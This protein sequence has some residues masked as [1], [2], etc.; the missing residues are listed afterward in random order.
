MKSAGR[1]NGAL[2]VG[3]G[4]VG[5]SAV[6]PF[7]YD[8]VSGLPANALAPPM[9]TEVPAGFLSGRFVQGE[10]SGG[11]AVF[12]P[13]G[14][15]EQPAAK[16]DREHPFAAKAAW[17]AAQFLWSMNA[18]VDDVAR[19]VFP[20]VFGGAAS[21]RQAGSQHAASMA[22]SRTGGG[23]GR[24]G[25]SLAANGNDI[26]GGGK[27]DGSGS[28]TKP[29]TTVDLASDGPHVVD[30]SDRNLRGVGI[31]IGTAKNADVMLLGSGVEGNIVR[32]KRSNGQME[33]EALVEGVEI[34]EAGQD[35]VFMALAVDTS[36]K[37]APG[38][39]KQIRIGGKSMTVLLPSDAVDQAA[40]ASSTESS[41]RGAG[42]ST[43]KDPGPATAV[44]DWERVKP[45][46]VEAKPAAAARPRILPRG[47][48]KRRPT[49]ASEAPTRAREIS[50][51]PPEAAAVHHDGA[52]S[53]RTDEPEAFID[54]MDGASAAAPTPLAAGRDGS[55]PIGMVLDEDVPGVEIVRVDGAL[56]IRDNRDPVWLQWD[57]VD[58]D[59][60][61]NFN[62]GIALNR[63]LVGGMPLEARGVV[64]L[65]PGD[66]MRVGFVSPGTV[67][68]LNP[69]ERAAS[70]FFNEPSLQG[71]IKAAS[72]VDGI[73]AALRRYGDAHPRSK[74]YADEIIARINFV[75]RNPGQRAERAIPEA[76]RGDVLR[77]LGRA[78]AVPVP[79]AEAAQAEPRTEATARSAEVVAVNL[80]QPSAGPAITFESGGDQGRRF[81]L[82]GFDP[83]RDGTWRLGRS[84]Q[85]AIALQDRRVS[86]LHAE[87]L[88]GRDGAGEGHFFIRDLGSSNGTMVNGVRIGAEIRL[89]DGDR[90][91]LAAAA[92]I[93][94]SGG[95]ASRSATS[96]G[97]AAPA[98][99]QPQAVNP[100]PESEMIFD[101]SQL[102]ESP[103]RTFSVEEEK[104]ALREEAERPVTDPNP[105]LHDLVIAG[106]SPSPEAFRATP[107]GLGNEIVRLFGTSLR[108]VMLRR[109][110]IGPMLTDGRNFR[111]YD[112]A[113]RLHHVLDADLI[114][115]PLLVNGQRVGAEGIILLP[116]DTLYT[117]LGGPGRAELPKA[118][119]QNLNFLRGGFFRRVVG[120]DLGL[121]GTRT[122]SELR[123]FLRGM[124][125]EH[126]AVE[127]IMHRLDR[128]MNGEASI[129]FLP[130]EVARRVRSI[131]RDGGEPGTT[132]DDAQDSVVSEQTRGR[133]AVGRDVPA[134][135]IPRTI[136]IDVANHRGHR[137][138]PDVP[139][140]WD[141]GG[142]MRTSG[143]TYIELPPVG[144]IE[145][146]DACLRLVY[147]PTRG[148]FL[149]K[150]PAFS[151]SART[152]SAEVPAFPSR[153]PLSPGRHT[154]S[155]EH[156]GRRVLLEVQI[157]EASVQPAQ[158][159]PS[160]GARP[161][162]QG[163][164]P[165]GARPAGREAAGARAAG[166]GGAGGQRSPI[167]AAPA[168]VENA[169]RFQCGYS[170]D[171]ARGIADLIKAALQA[172]D[173]KM[174]LANPDRVHGIAL[175]LMNAAEK[176]EGI[177]DP[178]FKEMEAVLK[179]VQVAIRPGQNGQKADGKVEEGGRFKAIARDLS[180]PISI[181]GFN[182]PQNPY[183]GDSP[184]ERTLSVLWAALRQ[185]GR[186]LQ[187][188][189][190]L[191][192]LRNPLV[193]LKAK[194]GVRLPAD[195]EAEL[196]SGVPARMLAAL[197]G[198]PN[199]R[200]PG[201]R[202]INKAR[203]AL[204]IPIPVK[205]AEAP[206]AAEAAPAVNA[207]SE[208]VPTIN[209]IANAL[210]GPARQ[211]GIDIVTDQKRSPL[212]TALMKLSYD[213][214][215]DDPAKIT[216]ATKGR[217][218][219][220]LEQPDPKGV[221]EA[222]KEMLKGYEGTD[223]VEGK[224]YAALVE[225]EEEFMR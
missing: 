162:A 222:L 98:T 60:T 75:A 5:G 197:E 216:A 54:W 37:C 40:G 168:F 143:S 178:A 50:P 86:V 149:V 16:E 83:Q 140:T 102:I 127:E 163:V 3:P 128:V 74:P 129:G 210:R 122:I 104:R 84:R 38:I 25:V 76:I 100:A 223:S 150:Y 203:A 125:A 166:N 107:G 116:G 46:P 22:A 30:L 72:T 175:R 115:L 180:E 185:N 63:F 214:K 109:T 192:A 39:R 13:L 202:A 4:V 28:G 130:E 2:G 194:E 99:R 174:N 161:V 219:R 190:E 44:V 92:F 171:T 51:N 12:L 224:G 33:I 189:P 42:P 32:I 59:K 151:G 118:A 112:E 191:A 58:V 193:A 155:I 97:G 89:N 169:L 73:V 34:G 123:S 182:G 117:P 131:I 108:G 110:R 160:Q 133:G 29:K 142:G 61:Q 132:I 208:P 183:T 41:Q 217:L 114:D 154:V 139:S 78:P 187:N 85:N 62:M 19:T 199:F 101:S 206:K 66:E 53:G 55:K 17:E 20:G 1:G 144:F 173:A 48:L 165:Q 121:R 36:E 111:R 6:M 212:I 201:V 65:L 91:E 145:F 218:D 49:D 21:R 80:A 88:Y 196:G 71:E 177:D 137:F 68:I 113:V 94:Q 134:A 15:G 11:D 119:D 220:A 221:V 24:K 184:I 148:F 69:L 106:G 10:A 135:A 56:A 141:I 198:L 159:A 67:R 225:Y 207:P 64:V 90:V 172:E 23:L 103:T 188:E 153:I 200:G 57:Q 205:K 9:G 126:P 179:E 82:A 136:T 195:I 81:E 35:T 176:V 7:V 211:K 45:T 79:R 105:A 43:A 96:A 52:A 77:V 138:S 70:T 124:V 8:A 167:D 93:F 215:F 158:R 14:S 157:P 27:A 152:A 156:R 181:A 146:P 164:P 213:G 209:R 47:G 186:D 95:L 18:F 87:I 147:E 204:G 120:T 31:F 26:G 170:K